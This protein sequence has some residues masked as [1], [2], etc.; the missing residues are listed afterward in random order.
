MRLVLASLLALAAVPLLAQDLP[1]E[2]PGAPDPSRAVAGVYQVDPDHTQV[3]FTIG[4]LGFSEYTG[5][6]THPT[7]TLTL[8][9]KNPAA[10][11]VDV[12]FPIAKV[13]TTSPEL[14]KHLQTAD[15]FDAAKYPTGRFVSTKVTATGD[16]SATIDGN[17]TL[18]GVTKPVTLD[19]RFV[20]AGDMVMG[21][22]VPNLG[23]A[24]TTTIKR[25][26]FGISYGIPLVSDD[27]LLTIN[28][29]F[30]KQ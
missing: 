28:A 20:G 26:D 9:P 15:F 19:V 25:S 11:K 12:S 7:G 6:F 29:A 5:M 18:H 16:G 27:V 10:D 21:P 22:P 23:F 24:A 4:H 30:A 2:A 17:L 1:K 14:D 8:D 3:V 13:L